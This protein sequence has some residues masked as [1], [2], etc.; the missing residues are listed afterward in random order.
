MSENIM[1]KNI[2]NK[3]KEANEDKT[4]IK[5]IIKDIKE[6]YYF[7]PLL[8]YITNL[9]QENERLKELINPKTQIFI[10]TQDIE[11]RYG[12]ELYQDYLK[13]QLD[14]Y[15]SRCEKAIKY[16]YDSYKGVENEDGSLPMYLHDT[17]LLEILGGKE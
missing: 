11:E 9:Q 7:K 17:E 5:E 4:K 2:A 14:D 12:E 8:D 10:D 13:E 15:K 6:I 16:I 3:M 1:Y